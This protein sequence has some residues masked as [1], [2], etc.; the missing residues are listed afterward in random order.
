MENVK[1]G[2]SFQWLNQLLC[3][4]CHNPSQLRFSCFC[5][6]HF[7]VSHCER[8]NGL[9]MTLSR[10]CSTWQKQWKKV[11]GKRLQ[12]YVR[13]A[14]P[15]GEKSFKTKPTPTPQT[16]LV[17]NT[18]WLIFFWWEGL[19]L[20]SAAACMVEVK[21]T[22]KGKCPECIRIPVLLYIL[23]AMFL[24][25]CTTEVQY[26]HQPWTNNYYSK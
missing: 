6:M 9:S 24:N 13:K 7:F 22:G 15:E 16:S 14:S 20:S 26:A 17:W 12:N 25:G 1:P 3:S 2:E 10:K 23:K 11:G 8:E 21:G 4:L 18:A 19:S 5:C